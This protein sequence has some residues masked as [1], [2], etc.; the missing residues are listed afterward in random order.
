MSRCFA[1]TASLGDVIFIVYEVDLSARWGWVPV[2]DFAL[3]LDAI[4]DA[5]APEGAGDEVFEFTESD[6]TIVFRRDGD[7]VEPRSRSRHGC[8]P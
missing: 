8:T 7:K 6:A 1:T 5:L 3:G 4:V 2:L